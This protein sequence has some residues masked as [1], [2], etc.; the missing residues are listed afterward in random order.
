MDVKDRLIEITI[1]LIKE[2]NG[3]PKQITIREIAKR[4]EVGVGLINYH[5][6]S[7][8]NLIEVCIQKIIMNVISGSKPDL[9]RLSPIERLKT[10]VKIP[11]DFLIDNQEVSKISI[12]DDLMN[13]QFEDN[14]FKTLEK[15]YYHVNNLNLNE[16][17]YFR[18]VFLLHGLQGIF[19]RWQLYKNNFDFSDKVARDKLLNNLLDKLFGGRQ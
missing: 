4:A 13:G 11:I 15:F 16:D 6:Q 19:L 5:F 12:L 18:T 14:S 2:K 1:S 8:E 10:S 7:K 3:K 17:D 9:E